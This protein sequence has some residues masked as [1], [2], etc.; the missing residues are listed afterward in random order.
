MIPVLLLSTLLFL[1]QCIPISQDLFEN[2]GKI[3]DA[4]YQD[5]HIMQDSDDYGHNIYLDDFKVGYV[6]VLHITAPTVG[7]FGLDLYDSNDN[8]VLRSEARYDYMGYSFV[9]SFAL[10]KRKDGVWFSQEL[11]GI[12][13]DFTSG[14]KMTLTVVAEENTFL[15]LQN[16]KQIKRVDYRLSYPSLGYDPGDL[17]VTSVRRIR[18]WSVRNEA[19]KD[20]DLTVKFI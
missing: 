5:V 19:A 7:N 3:L 17:P 10:N 18:V 4:S 11:K 2:E 9:K 16:N 14:L 6:V 20:A 12:G 13:F 15:I 8:I 1:C